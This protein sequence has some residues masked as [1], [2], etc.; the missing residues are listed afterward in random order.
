[1][2]TFRHHRLRRGYRRSPPI[3]R[4]LSRRPPERPWCACEREK[5]V[6]EKAD[7]SHDGESDPGFPRHKRRPPAQSA[8]LAPPISQMRSGVLKYERPSR[9]AP[10]RYLP[11]PF[12]S[13]PLSNPFVPAEG[14]HGTTTLAEERPGEAV[15]E[16]FDRIARLV[17]GRGGGGRRAGGS[18]K[19]AILR[20]LR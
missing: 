19:L 13:P 20:L 2:G 3:L 16:T 8:E 11:V 10:T 17:A 14:G 15:P 1:M 4:G 5:E 6:P 9:L 18:R 7:Q 12:R